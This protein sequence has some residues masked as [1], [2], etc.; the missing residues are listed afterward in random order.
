MDTVLPYTEFYKVTK[1]S[2][3]YWGLHVLNI[4]MSAKR[5]LLSVTFFSLKHDCAIIMCLICEMKKIPRLTH[6]NSLIQNNSRY[7]LPIHLRCLLLEVLQDIIK[8]W[9]SWSMYCG[10]Y[11]G[12]WDRNHRVYSDLFIC[13]KWEKRAE[14]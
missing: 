13:G 3:F 5:N 10:N 9:V 12:H 6:F 11:R 4:K 2:I 8:W 14:M 7:W 1:I